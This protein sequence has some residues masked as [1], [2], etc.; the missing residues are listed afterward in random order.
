M[1][2]TMV[3]IGAGQLAVLDYGGEPGAVPVL[4][5]HSIGNC[6]VTWQFVTPAFGPRIH[7]YAY[8]MPGHGLST[9]EVTTFDEAWGH[10]V[11]LTRALGLDR[12]LLVAHDQATFLCTIAA[13]Q[14]PELFRGVVSFGGAILIDHDASREYVEFATSP[15]FA[16]MLRERF[17]LGATGTRVEEAKA[18]VDRLVDRSEN[19][20]LLAG[21]RDGLRQEVERSLLHREDGTW[22]HRPA[23]ETIQRMADLPDGTAI[24]PGPDFYDGLTVPLWTVQLREGYENLTPEGAEFIAEHPLLRYAFL[25][26]NAWPQYDKPRQVAAMIER[27]AL[28]PAAPLLESSLPR[29]A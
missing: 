27:I 11:E 20:W 28:D 19:D 26:A 8:D 7:A 29:P 2:E 10:L 16:Q 9:A 3:D 21:M 23:V 22:L 15:T 4:L 17:F 12:P 24:T 6:A 5:V 14:A 1:N 18:L 13:T 25:D